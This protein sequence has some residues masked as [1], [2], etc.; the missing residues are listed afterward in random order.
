MT[1]AVRPAWD[2]EVD[3]L[4]TL[5]VRARSLEWRVADDGTVELRQA[6]TG[7]WLRYARNAIPL[8]EG[9]RDGRDV[10]WMVREV[11]ARF[12][13]LKESHVRGIVRSI[14]FGMW[15]SGNVEIDLPPVPATFGGRYRRERE[16]GRGG[17]GVAW[18]ARDPAGRAVVVKHAWNFLNAFAKAEDGIRREAAVMRDLAHPAIARLVDEVVEEGRFHIVREFVDGEDLSVFAERGPPPPAR[19]RAISREIAEALAHVHERGYLFLDLK[20]TNFML[21]AADGRVRLADVGLCRPTEKGA[22][23]LKGPTGSRGYASPE[24]VGTF[25]ATPASDVYGLGRLHYFL[26][27]GKK[28]RQNDATAA[29]VERMRAL[30]VEERDAAVVA[31]LAA[32]DPAARP[33]TMREAMTFLE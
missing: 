24:M 26:A 10:A 17:V 23:V 3:G 1:E 13:D 11:G 12:P 4:S 30:D 7:Q 6:R 9:L 21:D 19:R 5:R 18:L 33:R 20:P 32:D 15:A 8:L 27:T 16:L 14:L 28:P 2:G 31:A 29:L 25:T 22:V